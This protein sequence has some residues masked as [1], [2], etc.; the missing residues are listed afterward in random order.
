MKKKI[1]KEISCFLDKQDVLNKLTEMESLNDYS[2]SEIHT[3]RAIEMLEEPNV[4]NISHELKMTRGAISK[5]ANRM[6]NNGL[7][8][9]YMAEGNRQKKFYRLTEKG[10]ALNMA[11]I[12]RHQ[13]WEDRDMNFLKIFDEKEIEFIFEFFKKY[14]EYME[15]E[16]CK[17]ENK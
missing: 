6:I 12:Q 14:N 13:E 2:Y 4:T 7:I 10:K 11:H 16:I 15:K 9:M 3:I 17:I 1:L 8:E 5:I